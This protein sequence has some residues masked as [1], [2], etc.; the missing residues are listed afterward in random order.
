MK[1]LFSL[2]C[3]ANAHPRTL[4]MLQQWSSS[5]HSCSN[6]HAAEHD[7]I[8]SVLNYH[9]VFHR[10]FSLALKQLPLPPTIRFSVRASWKN[11]LPSLSSKV[12]QHNSS[13]G[14][15]QPIESR[16]HEKHTKGCGSSKN[17]AGSVFL[18]PKSAQYHRYHGR[19]RD[20]QFAS[21]P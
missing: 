15:G 5:A 3:G 1:K 2:Y 21:F 8:E 20:Y 17:V 10:A 4:S 11:A 14:S 9:P 6:T 12:A 16:D 19:V 7:K 18:Y 13:L